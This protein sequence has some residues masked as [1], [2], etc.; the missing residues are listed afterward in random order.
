MRPS[1]KRMPTKLCVMVEA[2]SDPPG[3][4]WCSDCV[5]FVVLFVGLAGHWPVCP[6]PIL[7]GGVFPRRGQAVSMN[8]LRT[9]SQRKTPCFS[10]KSQAQRKV[11]SSCSER[12]SCSMSG[13]ARPRL[14]RLM[15]QMTN[16]SA[17]A[18][19]RVH[20]V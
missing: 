19:I 17:G 1:C 12:N 16:A 7:S 3:A 13:S 4:V 5:F 10:R 8:M 9:A 11:P 2:R 6:A 20:Q 15:T 18:K 14:P